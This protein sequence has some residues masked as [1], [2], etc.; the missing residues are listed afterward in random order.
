MTSTSLLFTIGITADTF[1]TT[2]TK[3]AISA[4]DDIARAA[5][6]SADNAASAERA[7]LARTAERNAAERVVVE[8]ASKAQS[9]INDLVNT[10]KSISY[11]GSSKA[12]TNIPYKKPVEAPQL[13]VK[14]EKAKQANRSNIYNTEKIKLKLGQPTPPKIQAKR[15]IEDQ[16]IKKKNVI[17]TQQAKA[18]KTTKQQSVSTDKSLVAQ[19]SAQTELKKSIP[20]VS[21]KA[22]DE[23]GGAIAKLEK[24]SAT[25]A[26]QIRVKNANV[27]KVEEKV[28]VDKRLTANKQKNSKLIAEKKQIDKNLVLKKEHDAKVLANKKQTNEATS[29]KKKQSKKNLAGKKQSDEA[30][31]L[32]NKKNGKVLT[33]KKQTDEIVALKKKRN[34]KVLTDRKHTDAKFNETKNLNETKLAE[35]K[36][37]QEKSLNNKKL[38]E[39]KVAETKKLNNRML[40]I[41]TKQLRKE[42]GT[43][44]Y[45]GQ[46]KHTSD[47]NWLKGKN[48]AFLPSQVA[49]RLS[50]RDFKNFDEFRGAVWRDIA[51]DRVLSQNFKPSNLSLMRNGKA[52]FVTNT[53][54][55][56]K[57]MR[58]ELDHSREIQ[59]GGS[60]YGLDNIRIKTPDAHVR[61]IT[62]KFNLASDKK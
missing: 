45:N 25:K 55:R 26:T 32:K 16:A 6:R 5:Q 14:F 31:V 44:S 60:V 11:S 57:R 39:R 34:N 37:I 23:I 17:D 30:I 21:G 20:K 48:S 4:V 54:Q 62:R 10:R 59:D 29:L 33:D 53:Q 7:A 8:K 41:S 2:P 9:R 43:S 18:I 3:A 28:Q 12:T 47:P 13:R 50:G 56:G 52:P 24:Q 1:A 15:V 42:P 38:T 27:K 58:Y 49:E 51:N 46:L 40:S 35:R 36:V 61:K 22:K 19:G